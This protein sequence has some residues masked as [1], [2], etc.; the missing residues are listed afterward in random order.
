MIGKSNK[1]NGLQARWTRALAPNSGLAN[2]AVQCS[3]DS[4]VVNQTL[5]LRINNCRQAG[6]W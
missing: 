6:L 3:T 5:V 4:F 1:D 2:V